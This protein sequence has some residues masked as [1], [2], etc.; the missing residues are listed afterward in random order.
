MKESFGA[1]PRGGVYVGLHQQ[2]LP[3]DVHRSQGDKPEEDYIRF[4]TDPRD[5]KFFCDLAQ[6]LQRAAS[7]HGYNRVE[8]A[9]WVL[10]MVR[11]IP[12]ASDPSQEYPRYPIETLRDSAGDCEDYA[13]LTA[14][15]WKC[16]GY[17]VALLYL[18]PA[19]SHMAVGI[20]LP[21]VVSPNQFYYTHDGKRYFYAE[22]AGSRSSYFEARIWS[23]M[24]LVGAFP[25]VSGLWPPVFEHYA[26][27]GKCSIR[28]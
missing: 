5:E 10:N 2:N 11:S 13:I 18:P 12:Y 26:V 14:K 3:L 1:F 16:M 4:V 6:E 8:T 17:D 27:G 7:S 15:I 24:V 25:S 20:S 23:A 19:V 28:A 21:Y 9:E 22:S